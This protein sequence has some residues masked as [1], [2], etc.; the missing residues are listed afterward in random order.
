MANKSQIAL[1]NPFDLSFVLHFKLRVVSLET[2][3]KIEEKLKPKKPVIED[4]LI[5]VPDLVPV[6][7]GEIKPQKKKKPVI[8]QEEEKYNDQEEDQ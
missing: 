2:H 8:A 6:I 7:A 3:N 5:K 4:E 1:S